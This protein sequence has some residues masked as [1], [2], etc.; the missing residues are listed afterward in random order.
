[1]SD[2]LAVFVLALLI[3]A[4]YSL[5]TKAQKLHEMGADSVTVNLLDGG[6]CGYVHNYE[7]KCANFLEFNLVK[8]DL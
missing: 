7:W 2:L 3:F 6:I 8:D 5:I 1:M 4:G